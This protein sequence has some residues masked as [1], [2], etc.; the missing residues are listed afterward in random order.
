MGQICME[1]N[2]H[3]GPLVKAYL[4]SSNTL[5]TSDIHC[6]LKQSSNK[7]LIMIGGTTAAA[8]LITGYVVGFREGTTHCSGGSSNWFYMRKFTP[9]NEYEIEYS[10]V[11]STVHPGTSDIGNFI[12][13]SSLATQYGGRLDMDSINNDPHS[14]TASARVWFQITG[15][16]TARRKIYGLPV[17]NSSCID[18]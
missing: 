9:D 8:T 18:W 17:R 15:F 14:S 1:R 5:N 6:I 7:H 4:G 13:C 10:T 11:M 16:S 2:Y 3:T 12:G